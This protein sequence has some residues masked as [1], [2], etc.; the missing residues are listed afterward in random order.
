MLRRSSKS[1]FMPR[2]FVFPG[3]AV[4]EADRVLARGDR[5]RGLHAPGEA[6]LAIAALREL[7]EEAGILIAGRGDGASATLTA[8]EM[9]ALRIALRDGAPFDGL[10][11]EH[12][13]ILDAGALTYYSN[14]ITPRSEPIRFD[15]HFFIARA[16]E[17]QIAAADAFEVHDGIWIAPPLALERARS[18]EM[19]IIFPTLKHLERLAQFDD[20]EA[21]LAH[22]REREIKPVMPFERSSGVFTFDNEAW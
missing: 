19:T 9:A 11:A 22:A 3:G 21:V 10:L 15:T 5:V 1:R 6:D 16:P 20:V 4:D 12:D 2:A 13:L 18:G 14:W 7:F 17:N 8:A